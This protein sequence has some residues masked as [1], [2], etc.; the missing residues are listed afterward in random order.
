[1]NEQGTSYD[2]VLVLNTRIEPLAWIE[3]TKSRRRS[4]RAK[5]CAPAIFFSTIITILYDITHQC[6]LTYAVANEVIF[7]DRTKYMMMFTA[8]KRI[9]FMLCCT[10]AVCSSNVVAMV[11]T[12]SV[13]AATKTAME[14]SQKAN[15]DPSFADEACQL[16]DSILCVDNDEIPLPLSAMPAAHALY[17]STLARVG[18]DR[19]A[20]AQHDKSLFYFDKCNVSKQITKAEADVL[21]AK[22]KSLQR[23]MRYRDAM[24]I[25]KGSFTRDSTDN[26]VSWLRSCHSEAIERAALC[27]MRMGDVDASILIL[28]EFEKSL[29]HDEQLNPNL[30]GMLGASLLLKSS[31]EGKKDESYLRALQLLQCASDSFV[32]PIYNWVHHLVTKQAHFNPFDSSASIYAKFAEAN[33]SPFDDP[34]LINLDDKVRLHSII[35]GYEAFCP[36]G[37]VL[38]LERDAMAREW[39]NKVDCDDLAW[40]LKDSAGYGSHGN[41]I[42]TTTEVLSTYDSSKSAK[43]QEESKLCQRIVHPPMLLNGRKFSLRVY[44]V[45]FPEGDTLTSKGKQ[46]QSAEFYVSTEGLVKFASELYNDE[47]SNDIESQYMTN[48]G[49]GDGRSSKQ[50]DFHYLK[51]QFDASKKDYKELWR[52]IKASIELVMNRYTLKQHFIDGEISASYDASYFGLPKILG[53]D[54]MLD[55]KTNPW[56]LEVNRFPGL[57][58]R[59]ASDS[60]VKRC[61]QYDA[62]V[63]ATERLGF[64]AEHMKKIRPLDYEGFSL[65]KL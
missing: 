60:R 24:V 22:S 1:M 46:I 62:W 12:Q 64:S 35:H 23:L 57:D 59:S 38:P 7:V 32:S 19:E 16:W 27:S 31:R 28:D 43:E 10:V 20:L 4:L 17:A 2:M 29:N 65:E 26:D 40:V 52:K 5:I 55:D 56:L 25:L 15:I 50:D 33:N 54:F 48:S 9:F 51:S 13:A 41:I 30:A 61:I 47:T 37:Y 63:T 53:F 39:A 34:D 6:L 8:E 14:L 11:I 21:L 45:Y 42:T 3:P 36:L 18:R 58:P 49:R 44:V